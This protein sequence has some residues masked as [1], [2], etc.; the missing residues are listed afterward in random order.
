MCGIHFV[1]NAGDTTSDLALDDF[2]SDCFLANQV[3]GTDSSGMFQVKRYNN[4]DGMPEVSYYKSASNGSDF[5]R[6]NQTKSL[7]SAARNARVTVGHVRAATQGAVNPANA[8]PFT[9]KRDDGSRLIG[10]HNG[11]LRG[12]RGKIG[13]D[14]H[15]VDSEW[16]LTRL[17]EDGAAAFEGFEGAWALVWYDSNH[18][19]TLFVARN[20]QRPLFYGLDTKKKVMIAASELGMLGWI[21][22]R[23]KIELAKDDKN[24]K[25]FYPEAGQ[26]MEVNIK[27]LSVKFYPYAEYK[28]GKYAKPVVPYVAPTYRAPSQGFVWQDSVLDKVRAALKA[29][30]DRANAV[31]EVAEEPPFSLISADMLQSGTSDEAGFEAAVR[32]ELDRFNTNLPSLE[33]DAP[34]HSFK[35]VCT[36]KNVDLGYIEKPIAR[37]GS[38]AEERSKA[39]AK[40]MFGLVVPFQGFWFDESDNCV[41]GD[42]TMISNGKEESFDCVLRAQTEKSSDKYVNWERESTRNMVIIGVTP[43]NKFNNNKP[44][45]VVAEIQAD[46]VIR[47]FDVD[48]KRVVH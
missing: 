6:E 10:V 28:A 14:E 21:A 35:N 37:R 8:H 48:A 1:I 42:V 13:S 19:D 27:N 45:Y 47:K 7:L 23:N 9:V 43:P 11:T 32:A 20:E 30:M 26:I 34:P 39:K 24:F 33:D 41:Y 25:Y 17:A 22:D 18:P 4:K 2:M 12:W 16:L 40:G 15:A 46:D 44:Y 3:R 29:G 36:T 5:I 31:E 38:S